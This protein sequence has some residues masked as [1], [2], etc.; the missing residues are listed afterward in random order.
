MIFRYKDG[1]YSFDYMSR[2]DIDKIRARSKSAE[3]GPWV[4]DYAEMAKKTVIRR[5]I[6]LAP[7]SVEMAKAAATESLALTGE[8]QVSFFQTG[9]LPAIE[10][11]T[12]PA[13]DHDAV[14]AFDQMAAEN[15][16]SG[17]HLDA[18]LKATAEPQDITV[19]Q[20]KMDAAA[21]FGNFSKAFNAWCEKA[22]KNPPSTPKPNSHTKLGNDPAYNGP[23][24]G[25][26]L[27]GKPSIDWDGIAKKISGFRVQ[28]TMAAYLDSIK[29]KMKKAPAWVD[30][31]AQKKWATLTED[32]YPF[33][34]EERA[35]EQDEADPEEMSFAKLTQTDEWQELQILQQ[36]SPDAYKEYMKGRD[37]PRTLDAVNDAINAI[38]E[39]SADKDGMP[40]E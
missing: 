3:S 25:M 20:L 5:H 6:K 15:N 24:P 34:G 21:D 27:A 7:L 18:F 13:I 8:S 19:E 28:K 12:V 14:A 17:P 30:E 29:G 4:T 40:A 31:Q 16:L 2:D 23:P 33:G 11:E 39:A 38:A 1:S 32:P 22:A 36:Q 10:A 37:L 26:N 9:E 35:E